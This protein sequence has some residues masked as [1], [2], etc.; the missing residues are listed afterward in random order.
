[1]SFHLFDYVLD[2]WWW[3]RNY[4]Y[5]SM[6]AVFVEDKYDTEKEKIDIEEYDEIFMKYL[7]ERKYNPSNSNWIQSISNIYS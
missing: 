6:S 7:S 2:F 4:A 3:S 1:M 5:T